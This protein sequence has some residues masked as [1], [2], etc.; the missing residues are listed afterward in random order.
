M[1]IPWV[2]LSLYISSVLINLLLVEKKTMLLFLVNNTEMFLIFSPFLFLHLMSM[3]DGHQ[4]PELSD[5]E[6]L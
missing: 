4:N 6:V 5:F 3:G 1:V 2:W